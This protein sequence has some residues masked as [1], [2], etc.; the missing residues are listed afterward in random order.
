MTRL[1]TGKKVAIYAAV[2][3]GAAALASA[4]AIRLVSGDRNA[5]PPQAD[6]TSAAATSTP[7]ETVFRDPLTG[8][9]RDTDASSSRPVAVMIEDHVDARPLSGLSKAAIVFEAPVEGGI[10]RF[11][12]I[13]DPATDVK[14]IGPVRSAR[15]YYL[16]W[17]YG[18]DAMYMHVGG[19]PDALAKISSG[20]IRDLNQFFWSQYFWRSSARVAPHNVYTSTDL[21]RQALA[22]R[23]WDGAPEMGTWLYDEAASSTVSTST[24]EISV[25]FSSPSY[26][27]RWRWDPLH[28]IYLRSVGGSTATD[29]DGSRQ[30]AANVAVAFVDTGV[31]DDVGRLKVQTVGSGSAMMFRDGEAFLGTWKKADAGSRLRFYGQDGQEFVWRPGSTW[32]EI[33]PKGT[34]VTAKGGDEDVS[35]DGTE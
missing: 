30:E 14:E 6:V 1:L 35:S 4:A 27:V 22:A 33:V 17:A 3:L 8:E 26:A 28:A 25:P 9:R 34:T 23:G 2:T 11:M 24:S 13:F 20:A 7:A 16:D 32:I 10:T 19:S 29:K 15:P 18:F 21:M 12:A 31:L 5:P